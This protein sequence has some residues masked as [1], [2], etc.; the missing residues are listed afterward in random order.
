MDSQ[1][2]Y[3]FCKSKEKKKVC[4]QFKRDDP[5]RVCGLRWKNC[6]AYWLVLLFRF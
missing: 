5:D 3:L 1:E 2:E 4:V 6:I